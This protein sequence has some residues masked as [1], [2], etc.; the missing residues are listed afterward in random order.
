MLF[1]LGGCTPVVWHS[2]CCGDAPAV[3]PTT[4]PAASDDP[5]THSP[6]FSLIATPEIWALF[7]KAEQGDANALAALRSK[8]DHGDARA[9]LNLAMLYDGG[10]LGNGG[11]DGKGF[12]ENEAEALKWFRK[13][14]E[15]RNVFAEFALSQ[16]VRDAEGLK[17]DRK[18]AEQG[19][20]VAQECLGTRYLGDGACGGGL[21]VD[22]AEAYFWL[23]L[24]TNGHEEER[25]KKML[26]RAQKAAVQK[27]L[28][29]WKRTHQQLPIPDLL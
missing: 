3:T 24:A 11:G 9:Q 20:P 13:A 28:K 29:D 4:A 19:L 1:S 14:A 21:K 22:Y 23:S 27:R 16:R 7:K 6:G 2:T 26:T 15:Q 17:W 8:A 25:F 12:M 10:D 18:A 5:I